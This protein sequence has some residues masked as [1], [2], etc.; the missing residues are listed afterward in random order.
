MAREHKM[1]RT[2]LQFLA[3]SA[4]GVFL[5]LSICT[6]NF[7]RHDMPFTQTLSFQPAPDKPLINKANRHLIYLPFL[8]FIVVGGIAGAGIV[9][10][11]RYKKRR[12]SNERCR[13]A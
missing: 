9:S 13:V 3:M 6:W 11:K 7:V 8:T 12:A 1:P 5:L 4:F 10:V 2:P